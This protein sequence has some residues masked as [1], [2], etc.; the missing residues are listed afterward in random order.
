MDP[1]WLFGF[2]C[3]R[4]TGVYQR[5]PFTLLLI[6]TQYRSQQTVIYCARVALATPQATL[7]LA[8]ADLRAHYGI[9][10]DLCSLYD[11][12][13]VHLLP[14]THRYSLNLTRGRQASFDLL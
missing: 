4:G 14:D 6:L 9:N 12:Y 5:N 11:I 8:S 1:A 2:T 13:V 7:L 10:L 3:Q